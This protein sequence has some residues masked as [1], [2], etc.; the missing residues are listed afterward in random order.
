[1]E[2]Q[3][4]INLINENP[5]ASIENVPNIMHCSMVISRCYVE[6]ALDYKKLS[7]KCVPH[8]LTNN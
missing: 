5:S 6:N 3:K 7:Y 1:M 2:D 8:N 4:I